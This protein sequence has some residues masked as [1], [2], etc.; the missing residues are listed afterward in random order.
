MSGIQ[1]SGLLANSAFD[2][3]SVVDQLIAAD[4]IPVTNLQKEQTTNSDQ[5]S[6]LDALK[7]QLT[8]LQ[9]AADAL[10]DS[11]AGDGSRPCGGIHACG[12]VGARLAAF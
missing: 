10:N 4:S 7:T 2:W 5:S 6:A 9:T 12:R 8:D 11:H 1:I 3:K